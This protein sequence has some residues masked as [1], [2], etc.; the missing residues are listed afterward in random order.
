MFVQT[1]QLKINKAGFIYEMIRGL[2]RG[3]TETEIKLTCNGKM[4]NFVSNIRK[5]V[6]MRVE[7]NAKMAEARDRISP[8]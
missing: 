8:A 6:S 3:C 7:R 4:L 1:K 2:I 5:K